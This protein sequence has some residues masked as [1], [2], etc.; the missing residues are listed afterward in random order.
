MRKSKYPLKPLEYQPRNPHQ[1]YD[2]LRKECDTIVIFIHGFLG[3]PRQFSGLADFVYD[4]GYAC[5]SLLLPGHGGTAR[6]FAMNSQEKWEAH[7]HKQVHDYASLYPNVYL[8]GHSMG[9][10]L[11]I[12]ESLCPKANVKGIILLNT[13]IKIGLKSRHSLYATK[14]RFS[15]HP[16]YNRIDRY[17]H[18]N[19]SVQKGNLFTTVSWLPRVID[20]NR[21]SK[22]AV[23]NLPQVKVPV[24]ITQSRND[25]AVMWRSAEIIEK[26]LVN[27]PYHRLVYLD[28]SWHAYYFKQEKKQLR[29]EIKCFLDICTNRKPKEAK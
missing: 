27:C 15:R 21:L 9:G 8:V 25:E 26:G 7:V 23:K 16:I 11:S 19:N 13:A 10:L 2:K 20:L 18:E 24:L 28:R 17:Y 29:D 5:A 22:I 1:A 12:N 3:S 14:N 6:D 4:L